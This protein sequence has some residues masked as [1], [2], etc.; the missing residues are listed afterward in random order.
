VSDYYP[1]IDSLR[2]DLPLFA[3]TAVAKQARNFHERDEAQASVL[4][5]MRSG[6][7]ITR[8]AY[9]LDGSRLAPSIEQLRNAHGFTI[10]GNG[11]V[12]RPYYMADVRQQPTL[13]RVTP[14][15]KVSYYA[16]PWWNDVRYR[17]LQRDAFQCVLCDFPDELRCHHVSYVNLFNEQLM[18][19]MTV[20]DRCHDR[21]HEH[22]GLKFPSGIALRYAHLV[23][24]KGFETWLLP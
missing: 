4:L 9:E 2:L 17:R 19:L 21:I 16:T 8:K 24:W 11:T 20:C 14:E 15:M 22:C 6:E 3:A 5:S 12:K 23:G 18:D 13:A 10:E 7:R 1:D